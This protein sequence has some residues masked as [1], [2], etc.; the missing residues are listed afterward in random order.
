[1]ED[2]IINILSKKSLNISQIANKL[3]V[4]RHTAAKYLEALEKKDYIKKEIKG[5]SKLYKLNNPLIEFFKKEDDI[6]SS[7]I[8]ELLKNINEHVSVQNKDFEVI[9]S[10]KEFEKGKKCYELYA[11][12]DSVC[13]NCPAEQTF[14]T[15]SS[16]ISRVKSLEKE[17]TVFP[18]KNFKDETIGVIELGKVN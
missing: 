11:N 15:G 18:V 3:E 4:E 7:Q 5:K 17:V 10:N 16:N 9:W 8:K 1:M 2:K 12:R 6:V 14:K 13:P